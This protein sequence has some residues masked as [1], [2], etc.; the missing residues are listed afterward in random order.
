LAQ[1]LLDKFRKGMKNRALMILVLFGLTIITVFVF[2]KKNSVP[3]QEEIQSSYK[4][5]YL[6]KFILSDLSGSRLDSD[7]FIGKMS[8]YNLSI[9]DRKTRSNH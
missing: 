2:Y 3:G 7:S 5:V 9:L 1:I 8:M 4:T 6:P